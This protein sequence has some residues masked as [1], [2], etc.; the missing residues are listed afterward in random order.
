MEN[1]DY[2]IAKQQMKMDERIFHFMTVIGNMLAIKRKGDD[3]AEHVERPSNLEE[4]L[5]IAEK[6]SKPFPFVRVDLFV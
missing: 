6:L 5:Y 4:M 3:L 2:Y 1:Q